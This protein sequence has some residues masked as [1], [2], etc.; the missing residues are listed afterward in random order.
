LGLTIYDA[1]HLYICEASYHSEDNC[2]YAGVDC[3]PQGARFSAVKACICIDRNLARC[4]HIRKSSEAG[5]ADKTCSIAKRL[6]RVHIEGRETRHHG[7]QTVESIDGSDWHRGRC[8]Q[9]CRGS[10]TLRSRENDY[11]KDE[12]G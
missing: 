12:S 8:G 10:L 9:P 7:R 3:R 4:V 1:P 11:G 2:P 5:Q 6:A